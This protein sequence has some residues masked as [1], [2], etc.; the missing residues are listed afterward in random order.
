MPHLVPYSASKFA[1]VG[2]SEGLRAELA[3][4]G[5]SV[6]TICPGLMRTGSP[7]HAIFK[8]SH[9]AEYAWF[10]ISDSLP[11][12]SMD[13]DRAARQILD[14]IRRGEAERVLS[15]PARIA[16]VARALVPEVTADVLAAVNRLLPSSDQAAGTRGRKGEVSTSALS[17][18]ILTVL[19]DLA[20]RRNNQVPG[21]S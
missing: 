16:T 14:A 20:A 6:T 18:S 21:P 10:N 3:K 19:G 12:V 9:R 4:D 1:L 7:R 8:G 17:P 15:V 5:I 2:L 13:A 11:L